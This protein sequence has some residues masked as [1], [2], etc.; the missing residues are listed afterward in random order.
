MVMPIVL[1]SGPVGAGKSTVARELI[2]ILPGPTVYIE[3]DTFWSFVVKRTVDAKNVKNFKMIMTSM[4]AAAVPYALYGNEVI[5]DFSIPPWFLDTVQAVAK[6]KNVPLD[7]V[8]LRPSL[9]VCAEREPLAAPKGRSPITRLIVTSIRPSMRRSVTSFRMI[10]ATRRPWLR[11]YSPDLTAESSAFH[12]HFRIEAV[13]HMNSSH[14]IAVI[15]DEVSQ[16]FGHACEVISHD[17]GMGWVE[18]RELWNKN[19]LNLDSGEVDEAHRIL[20]KNQLRVV[21]IASP[22]FKTDWPGA[23]LVGPKF[24]TMRRSVQIKFYIRSAG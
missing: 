21:G 19:I 2:K 15:T 10:R 6:V 9:Q 4:V 16:D 20:E 17:F 14:K 8:V 7:L 12:D 22:L 23:A 5:L 18:L 11:A 13:A 24:S 3:G 1:L